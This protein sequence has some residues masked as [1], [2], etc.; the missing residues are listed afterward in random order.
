MGP[1]HIGP[2]SITTDHE[3][4]VKTFTRWI[5]NVRK[6]KDAK[7]Q[8]YNPFTKFYDE[9]FKDYFVNNDEDADTAPFDEK[10]REVIY[11]FL[12]YAK[13]QITNSQEITEEKKTELI[14]ETAFL[15]RNSSKLTKKRF[16]VWLSRF[17]KDVQG[18]SI[19]LY[20]DVFDV[21]KKE[22]I[23]GVLIAS[24]EQ[25]PNAIHYLQS[26]LPGHH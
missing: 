24:V 3:N 7:D 25:L 5:D 2:N 19:M 16:A 23:K 21:L 10:R 15:Q 4:A 14:E 12:E 22:A 13:K 8:Y 20:H 17:A 26:L 11:F 6:L 1:S 9:E 18:A